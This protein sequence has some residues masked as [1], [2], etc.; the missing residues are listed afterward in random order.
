MQKEIMTVKPIIKCK[1]CGKVIERTREES[2]NQE[3]PVDVCDACLAL[4]SY[5]ED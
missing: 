5:D 4:D 2:V 1:E 3:L